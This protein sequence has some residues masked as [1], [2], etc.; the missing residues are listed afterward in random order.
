MYASKNVQTDV[1]K[2]KCANSRAQKEEYGIGK[3]GR[4]DIR[5]RTRSTDKPTSRPELNR[6]RGHKT[7]RRIAVEESRRK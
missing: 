6:S 1:C 7:R 5:P 3:Q 2:K 4:R